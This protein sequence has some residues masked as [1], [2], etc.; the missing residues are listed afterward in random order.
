MPEDDV[1]CGDNRADPSIAERFVAKADGDMSDQSDV[2]TAPYW[3]A[4]C[5]RGWTGPRR[6]RYGP[7]WRDSIEHA[8]H[9]GHETGVVDS[10]DD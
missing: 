5:D 10:Y 1:R 4:A 8:E 2:P 9:T 6:D 3:Y 7:A